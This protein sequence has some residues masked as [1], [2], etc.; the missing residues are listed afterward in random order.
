[1]LRLWHAVIEMVLL[2]L[3]SS[4]SVFFCFASFSFPFCFF[5]K[6]YLVAACYVE[7]TSFKR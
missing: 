5:L 6:Q 2:N 3:S 7:D 4:F 1:M